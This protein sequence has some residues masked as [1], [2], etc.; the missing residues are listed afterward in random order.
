[1]ADDEFCVVG[2]HRAE[3]IVVESGHA[4]GKAS[5]RVADGRLVHEP[6]EKSLIVGHGDSFFVFRSI[7][8]PAVTKNSLSIA[9]CSG[10][11]SGSLSAN[12]R[13]ASI[14][15]YIPET[16]TVEEDTNGI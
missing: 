9:Y 14:S 6:F 16:V 5:D 1:M 4:I 10:Y 15:L 3:H 7:G 12:A 8:R 13:M 2:P 11:C